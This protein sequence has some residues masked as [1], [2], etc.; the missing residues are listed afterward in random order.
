MQR[1]EKARYVI[2]EANK[3]LRHDL[4]KLVARFEKWQM[5]FNFEKGKWVHNIEW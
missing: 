4:T 3:I 2:R 5:L 1:M